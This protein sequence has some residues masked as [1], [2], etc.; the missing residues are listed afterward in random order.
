VFVVMEL[1]VKTSHMILRSS[2]VLSTKL[3]FKVFGFGDSSMYL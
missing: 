1:F 2:N 3:G